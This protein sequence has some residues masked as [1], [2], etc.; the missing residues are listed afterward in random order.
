MALHDSQGMM[1]IDDSMDDD[2]MDDT[3]TEMTRLMETHLPRFAGLGG[4]VLLDLG[5]AGALLLD[6]TGRTPIAQRV[7]DGQATADC[8]IAAPPE[9]MAKL[10]DGDLNP[11][12]AFGLGKV[13]VSGKMELVMKLQK[14]LGEK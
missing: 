2:S 5:P 9:V 13:K 11:M 12:L 8:T 7:D 3:T 4:T 1:G 10:L 6:G 14:I